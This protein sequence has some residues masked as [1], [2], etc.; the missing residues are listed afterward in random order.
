[1]GTF[2]SRSWMINFKKALLIT[3]N[4]LRTSSFSGIITLHKY[5]CKGPRNSSQSMDSLFYKILNNLQ[6]LF[7]L[8]ISENTSKRGS[9][10]V[11][12]CSTPGPDPVPACAR[13]WTDPRCFIADALR[14]ASCVPLPS[15]AS[16]WRVAPRGPC[17]FS[18]LP[19]RP[20]Y[21]IKG[22]VEPRSKISLVIEYHHCEILST[23]HS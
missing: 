3:A 4:L 10:T 14:V 7:Q 11:M 15:R 6:T 2:S 1:M 18:Y 12:T 21:C 8:N 22:P 13:P 16:A 19:Y 5:T 17:G 20:P 9:E 23:L